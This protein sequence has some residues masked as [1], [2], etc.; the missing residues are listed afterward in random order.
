MNKGE[1]LELA[2]RVEGLDGNDPTVDELTLLASGWE[3]ERADGLGERATWIDPEGRRTSRR[4]G[5]GWFRPT[6]SL[7]AAMALVPE[8]W[9]VESLTL[10][11]HNGTHMDA[12]W[13]FHSTTDSGATPAPSIDE[14][15]L[16]LFFRPGV[17]LDFSHLPAGHVVTAAMAS[18]MTRAANMRTR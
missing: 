9:A 4:Q 8:G 12:P 13:H 10:S 18:R 17:K 2:E 16:D 7:D 3:L 6:S 5:D 15:P 1:I 11:T 14:A